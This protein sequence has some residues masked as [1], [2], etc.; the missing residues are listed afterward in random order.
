MRQAGQ[1]GW[2]EGAQVL[3]QSSRTAPR[4]GRA[5]PRGG[6]VGRRRRDG[7]RRLQRWHRGDGGLRG[8]RGGRLR[9]VKVRR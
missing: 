2:E 5:A 8:R 6:H 1:E 4:R 3:G 7:E 9:R